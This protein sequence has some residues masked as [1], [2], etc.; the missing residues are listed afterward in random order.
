MERYTPEHVKGLNKDPYLMS[1]PSWVDLRVFDQG[2][3]WTEPSGKVVPLHCMDSKDLEQL[4][5]FL[6][7]NAAEF[8]GACRSREVTKNV[9]FA[10]ALGN[11]TAASAL[12]FIEDPHEWLA[13]TPLMLSLTFMFPSI[14]E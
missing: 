2:E 9:Y 6:R 11:R 10:L 8:H 5:N 1:D 3:T 13:Q 14:F 4:S 12:D 7:E